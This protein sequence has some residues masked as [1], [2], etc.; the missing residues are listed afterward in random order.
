MQDWLRSQGH[1]PGPSDGWWGPGTENAFK[2]W[3][4]RGAGGGGGGETPG[5][6]PTYGPNNPDPNSQESKGAKAQIDRTLAM[7]GLSPSVGQHAWNLFLSG[8]PVEQIMLEI[9]NTGE[10]KQRFGGMASLQSKGRAISESEYISMESQY[11]AVLHAA[12]LPA[13]FYDA[14]DDFAGWIGNDV[15]PAEIQRR[16][17][18]ANKQA[19][20]APKETRDELRRL[21]GIDEGGIAAFFLDP[22]RAISLLEKQ[23]RT[24]DVSGFAMRAGLRQLGL[25]EAERFASLDGEEIQKRIDLYVQ[26]AYGQPLEVK[27]ELARLYGITDLT[28]QV[29]NPD[30]AVGRLQQQLQASMTGGTSQRTGFGNLSV[31]EAERLAPLGVREEDFSKIVSEKELFEQSL[32]GQVPEEIVGRGEQIDVLS[33]DERARGKVERK[34]ARRKAEFA[35]GGGGFAQNR[36]GGFVGLGASS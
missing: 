25:A 15:S 34:R 35:G 11:A 7:F 24:A 3:Q 18:L 9:R 13:G 20:Q 16:A 2:S 26:S 30:V 36:E 10:Y 21:Y 12:G 27:Q 14:P 6:G 31:G 19:Y 17:E 22:N 5:A 29:V 4:S 32:P 33:G 1:D 23:S 8:M 28:G